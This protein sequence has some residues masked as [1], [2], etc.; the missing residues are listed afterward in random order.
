MPAIRQTAE[1]RPLV[2]PLFE[3]RFIFANRHR[4]R[5][6]PG[7]FEP[8]CFAKART[9]D[10]RPGALSRHGRAAAEGCVTDPGRLARRNRKPAPV[11]A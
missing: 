6:S 2:H 8:L 5:I 7:K 9:E 4:A 1:E 11:L 10:I 3:A